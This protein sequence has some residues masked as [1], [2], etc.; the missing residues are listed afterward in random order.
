MHS[1]LS[2]QIEFRGTGLHGGQPVKMTVR[3]AA[4]GHGIVFHRTD[5]SDGLVPA[6][7]DLVSDT[8]L[9]TKLTND[10]G[11]SIGT[12][13]HLMAA[14]A[15]CGI[16]DALIELD[17]P[18]VP[19]MDGSASDF[20]DAFVDTGI[21]ELGPPLVAIRI[22]APVRVESEGRVAELAPADRF[23]MRF[24]ID[25]DDAAIGEQRHEMTLVNG[26]FV[27]EL[28]DCR[29]FGRLAE[30]E[31]LRS[32]GLARGGNLTNAIV[33]DGA[34]V[35]NPEGL[36]RPD[37]FVRHKMLDAV[38]DLAL[39]GAPIIGRYSAEKAGHEVTNLLLRKLFATPEAWKWDVLSAD[40]GLG[41]HLEGRAEPAAAKT[42][43]V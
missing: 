24:A 7:Y 36:R 14:L 38:G 18:E 33:I 22:L 8:R 20:V 34:R 40:Q 10:H 5:V 15:G 4:A 9:C 12:V 30:V 26:A 28:S 31:Y 21:V 32:I 11:V 25:F 41:G 16:S 2:R 19:I 35:L 3:P 13:E 37:E 39:A 17:G 43:A 1:S 29:T 6:R 42:I 23:E 27:E